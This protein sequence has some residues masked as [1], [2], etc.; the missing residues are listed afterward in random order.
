M[1]R[2]ITTDPEILAEWPD[3]ELLKAYQLTA[4]EPGD[5]EVDALL[6]EIA[7]RNLDL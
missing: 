5:E 1:I 3:A 2:W 6:A 4:G 7:R